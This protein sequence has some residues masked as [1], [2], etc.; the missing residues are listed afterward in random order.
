MNP[1]EFYSFRCAS[2]EADSAELMIFS[3]IGD[4]E[5]MGDVSARS[6]AKA[7]A[8]LPG[9]VKRLDIHINSPGGSVF[10]A[11]AIYSRLADHRSTKHVYVDG[12][13]ASAASI[14]AMVGHKIY[15]RSNATMMVHLPSGLAMGN[16]DDMRHMATA[17]DSITESMINVYTKRTGQGRDEIRALLAAETW[18]D[19]ATAVEQGFADEVRGVVKAAAV[20]GEKRVVINGVEHDLSR[21]HNVPAFTALTQTKE[22]PMA[23]PNAVTGAAGT[24][25]AEEPPT[26]RPGEE[27]PTPGQTTPPSPTTTPP[28]TQ[29]PTP[30]PDRRSP[31][32]REDPAASSGAPAATESAETDFQRGLRAERERV[33]ALQALDRPA[34]HAIVQAAI[35][36][37]KQP[38]DIFAA[39]MDAM[40]KANARTARYSDAAQLNAIPGSDGGGSDDS[41]KFGAALKKHVKARAKGVR[42]NFSRN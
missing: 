42:P 11:Q 32:R 19:P 34:T 35:K 33:T 27:E 9:S 6:F 20:V 12:L 29:P 31:E 5:D 7:L 2:D 39:C 37:G 41:E 30:P 23:K 1:N 36:D 26:R 24:P 14:I 38:S 17:L 22:K 15:I 4:W 21:F 40:E 28:P 13:A 18:L 16:A 10:E 8:T 3:Q 25:P